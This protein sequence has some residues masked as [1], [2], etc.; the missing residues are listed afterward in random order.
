M[1][2]LHN[3]SARSMFY[4][5]FLIF[6]L[7]IGVVYSLFLLDRHNAVEQQMRTEA[8]LVLNDEEH[9]A[10]Q[11][12][13]N[14]SQEID[15]MV[16]L[17]A[18]TIEHGHG[19]GDLQQHLLAFA[20]YHRHY[21]QLRYL[22][23]D[24]MEIVRIDRFRDGRVTVPDVLQN[25]AD[26]YYFI[27]AQPLEQGE[28]YV[29]PLDLNVEF[30]VIEVPWRP[31]MRFVTPVYADGKKQGYF[32]LNYCMKALIESFDEE[33]GDI[34]TVLLNKEGYY[35]AGGDKSRRFG[36]MFDRAETR[37][38]YDHPQAWQVIANNAT[39]DLRTKNLYGH[40]DHYDPV[41]TVSPD[42]LMESRLSWFIL[43]YFTEAALME[44]FGEEVRAHLPYLLAL[45]LLAAGLARVLSH[46]ILNIRNQE[47][48]YLKQSNMAAMGQMIGMIAHQWR[49]PLSAIAA[50]TGFMKFKNDLS[51][52]FDEEYEREFKRIE[53]TVQHLSHTIDDFM[54]FY[55]SSESNAPHSAQKLI[56]KSL[57]LVNDIYTGR[58][59]AIVK[60][61]GDGDALF[62]ANE[63]QLLQ[64][65]LNL[66]DNAKDAL[67]DAKPEAMTIRIT[68]KSDSRRITIII[69]DN[70][71]GIPDDVINDIFE[72]YYST[73]GL[74]G[75]GLGLYM[76]HTIVTEQMEGAISVENSAQG[77]KFTLTFPRYSA[78]EA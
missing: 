14:I 64:V 27:D 49:Q 3:V 17:T 58:K 37:F 77:A 15:T 73:K 26:R 18:M 39:G 20:R 43:A 23:N 24:G 59:I 61:Y 54:N 19:Y 21:M 35:L 45:I 67:L 40:F 51:D 42:R 7:L 30:G 44:R 31:V 33:H 55:K 22:D 53:E 50:A 10:E 4:G 32:I 11:L 38:A 69:E 13:F 62:I 70:G 72:P 2:F 76:V 71:G 25:K 12:F 28:I 48:M 78:A 5:L 66:F 16:A 8:R 34:H 75:T 6:L 68:T 9:L 1:H 63:R 46:L 65:F 52:N 56:E 57:K 29:S 47:M 36:F 41:A 60:N 74:N